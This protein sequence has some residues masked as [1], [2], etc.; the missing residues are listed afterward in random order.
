M[1]AIKL[2]SSTPVSTGPALAYEPNTLRV[3]NIPDDATSV[4]LFRDTGSGFT[5]LTDMETTSVQNRGE[6]VQVS[7]TPTIVSGGV[8]S[9]ML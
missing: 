6:L 3:E 9:S 4:E 7:Y 1:F 8:Y 2:G 5:K